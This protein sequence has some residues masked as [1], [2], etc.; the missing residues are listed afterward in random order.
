MSAER[1]MVN[2][3]QEQPMLLLPVLILVFFIMRALAS[4][5]SAISANFAN[6]QLR[7]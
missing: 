1:M 4:A 2:A 5:V 6:S 7:Y 3:M